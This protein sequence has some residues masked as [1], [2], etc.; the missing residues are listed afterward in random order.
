MW[1]LRPRERTSVPL[2][3]TLRY[4][5][6]GFDARLGVAW[7][8]RGSCLME[9][10]P[11]VKAAM[12]IVERLAADW[13]NSVLPSVLIEELG[14]NRSTCY[15]ILATLQRSGWVISTGSRAGYSLGPR[16]LALTGVRPSVVTAVVQHELNALTRKIS[17]S[18]Y[19]AEWERSGDYVVVAKSEPPAGIYISTSIGAKIEFSAIALLAAFAAWTP[20]ERVAR[21]I[22]QRG[23]KKF[24]EFSVTDPKEF[25][26]YLSTVRKT[27]YGKS[28]QQFDLSQCA[29][30]A[31]VFD[32]NA[33]PILAIC[34]LGFS[35]ELNE[36][37]VEAVGPI[38]RA[39]ADSVTMRI[40]GVI[41]KPFD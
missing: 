9:K 37:A 5:D 27:G 4:T 7:G 1:L 14:L 2:E 17:L 40:G 33:R 25:F 29:V 21:F 23:L 16:L 32:E 13:P 28:L 24:T 34:V 12:S 11:A 26:R 18:A 20:E 15:N 3:E 35:N 39:A 38:I 41:P 10:V 30:A 19:A 31:P 22:E 8:A 36:A 6:A